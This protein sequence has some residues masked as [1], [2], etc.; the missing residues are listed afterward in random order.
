[1]DDLERFLA[2]RGVALSPLPMIDG[3]LL[4]LC[5]LY[6]A[7]TARGGMNVV[8]RPVHTVCTPFG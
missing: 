4:D 3:V 7:V 2:G 8:R 1:M 6:Q 5:K